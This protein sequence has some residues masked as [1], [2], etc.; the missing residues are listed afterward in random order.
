MFSLCRSCPGAPSS[1]LWGR[2]YNIKQVFECF[3]NPEAGIILVGNCIDTKFLDNSVQ[4]VLPFVSRNFHKACANVFVPPHAVIHRG[5]G[6]F[7]SIILIIHPNLPTVYLSYA[8]HSIDVASCLYL[9][10]QFPV[11]GIPSRATA[12]WVALCRSSHN[13][14]IMS[15][16]ISF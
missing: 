4:S 13:F 6:S 16:P 1:F 5:R 3:A 11:R 15:T 12:G 8:R 7:W 10:H 9:V 2:A 14:L